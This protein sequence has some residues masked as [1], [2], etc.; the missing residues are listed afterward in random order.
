MRERSNLK[1]V[2]ETPDISDLPRN[3]VEAM[4]PLQLK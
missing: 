2:V 3:I 4:L 1:E